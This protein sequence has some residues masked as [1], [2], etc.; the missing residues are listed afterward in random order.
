MEFSKL[1]LSLETNIAQKQGKRSHEYMAYMAFQIMN[2]YIARTGKGK[3]LVQH[4]KELIQ[5]AHQT[6]FHQHDYYP[7]MLYQLA[8]FTD[9]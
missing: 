7:S 4:S 3:E 8:S 9:E 6:H 1:A 5:L 2:E